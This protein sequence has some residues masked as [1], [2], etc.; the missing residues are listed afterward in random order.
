VL[1]LTT[2]KQMLVW[3]RKRK[4]WNNENGGL[5]KKLVLVFVVVVG[6]GAVVCEKENWIWMKED[7]KWRKM[8][9]E[10]NVRKKRRA[11]IASCLSFCWVVVF[12]HLNVPLYFLN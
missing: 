8:R 10:C 2:Q 1:G 7:E 5:K 4:R 6:F 12:V 9:N 3:R 11:V